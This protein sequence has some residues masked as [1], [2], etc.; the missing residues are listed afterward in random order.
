MAM[1]DDVFG[2]KKNFA[3][4]LYRWARLALCPSFEAEVGESSGVMRRYRCIC[5]DSRTMMVNNFIIGFWA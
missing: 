4:E 5:A 2:E 3:A 1:S